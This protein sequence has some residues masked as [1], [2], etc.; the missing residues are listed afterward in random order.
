MIRAARPSRSGLPRVVRFGRLFRVASGLDGEAGRQAN[1]PRPFPEHQKADPVSWYDWI[2]NHVWGS[3]EPFASGRPCGEPTIDHPTLPPVSLPSGDYELRVGVFSDK[4]TVRDHNEDNFFVLGRVGP[5]ASGPEGT[6]GAPPTENGGLPGLFIVADGMGG[7]NAGEK[8][9][10]M[11]VT[12]VPAEL[13]R[14]LGAAGGE[15]E[16]STQRVVREAVAEV[17]QEIL[18]QSHLI[19]EFANMGTTIV[20]ALFRGERVFVTG[21]GDSRAYRL[22]E[23]KLERL[24]RDHSLA[25]ALGEAGTIRP[26]EVENHKFRNVLYLYLGCK[27]AR[28]GPE[29]I[30]VLD[31]KRG[32]RFLLAT[33][34]LTGVVR[35]DAIAEALRSSSDPQR[36]ARSLVHRALE[37]RSRDNVTCVVVHVQ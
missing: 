16:K 2:R 3:R 8:A 32:D 7:Q 30:H 1:L 24:T 27:D 6:P 26:E 9:S 19:A 10:E 35:D 23:E 28:E 29:E 12:L 4:G 11:A 25:D 5:D 15:D 14:R 22:R 20:L 21:I 36:T 13:R 17:N 37:N 34:G 31:V 33:D 18:A